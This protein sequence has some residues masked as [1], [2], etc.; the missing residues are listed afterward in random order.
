M[1][2][3]NEKLLSI[4][5]ITQHRDGSCLKILKI[6]G[7]PSKVFKLKTEKKRTWL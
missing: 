3:R 2:L 7:S 4:E 5:T 6:K 1:P